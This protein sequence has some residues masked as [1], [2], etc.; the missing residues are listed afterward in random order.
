MIA[1]GEGAIVEHR[2]HQRLRVVEMA[3]HGDVVDVGRADR[4]HLPPL[5]LRHAAGGVEHE[6]FDAVAPRQRVD[7]S[8]A[9]VAAGC[10]DHGHVPGASRKKPL[11][12]QAE[13]LHGHILERE[14]RP[15]EQLEEPLIVVELH[16]RGDGGVGEAAIGLFA[17]REQRVRGHR[18]RDEGREHAGGGLRVGQAVQRGDLVA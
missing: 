14:R 12:Q 17:Q 10:A 4:G 5:H 16:Q 8:R 6:H 2:L 15:V 13:Q 9:G 18:I 1:A 11:E 7:R 3:L